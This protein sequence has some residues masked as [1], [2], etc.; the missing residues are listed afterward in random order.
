MDNVRDLTPTQTVSLEDMQKQQQPADAGVNINAINGLTGAA[1]EMP[2]KRP[3]IKVNPNSKTRMP[4]RTINAETTMNR[5]N[6]NDFIQPE[7]HETKTMARTIQDNAVSMLD[8]AVKRKQQEFRD[9]IETATAA[10]EANREKVRD[11]LEEISGEI[12]YLPQDLPQSVTKDPGLKQEDETP[13]HITKIDNS[14]ARLADEDEY[15]DD[16]ERDLNDELDEEYYEE[17]QDEDPTS[18]FVRV[19]HT[20]FDEEEEEYSTDTEEIMEGDYSDTDYEYA[21]EGEFEEE[22]ELS[23]DEYYDEYEED[24]QEV[25]M[26][27]EENVPVTETEE[28][29]PMEE[30][31]EEE[32]S[33]TDTLT[34]NAISISSTIDFSDSSTITNSTSNDFNLDEDDFDDVT[35]TGENEEQLTDEQLKEIR[36]ESEKHLRSEILEKV[37]NT[38]KKLDTTSFRI[39]NKIVSINNALSKTE[40]PKEERFGYWPM[41]ISGRPFKASPLK[42]PEIAL[43]SESDDSALEGGVGLTL[44]QVR[45]MYDHD[46]NEFKPK[47]IEGWAK[48]IP[49]FD[50]D[51]IFAALYVASLKGANYIPAVCSKASCGYSYLRDIGDIYNLVKF[52]DDDQKKKFDEVLHTPITKDNTEKYESVVNVINDKFAVGLKIPSVYTALYEYAS[53]N[54]EFVR[55]YT[56]VIN[57]MQYVDYIYIINPETASFEP[58]GWKAYPGDATKTFKSKIAT[59]SKILKELDDTDFSVLVALINSMVAK[60]NERKQLEYEIPATKCPKCGADIAAMT[61]SPRHMV[62]MRQRL[63]ELATIR[64]GR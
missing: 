43:L 49:F 25:E 34:K 17:D 31:K 45:I 50:I 27:A 22:E 62:F 54:Q 7:A 53:L 64:T 9:F 1:E 3:V 16:V 18:G 57:I 32:E 11:G 42:G 15:F 46:A 6:P 30:K 19:D 60:M 37:I 8:S 24:P 59:Y 12:N 61:I 14:G 44:Q 55:K 56:S 2:T 58:I 63:V 23:Q 28:E 38:G 40:K 51:S 4:R 26:E 29:A 52:V 13:I 41:M 48:T 10:D 47:T 36:Q 35:Y 21:S 39:S 20:P 5:V 33:I